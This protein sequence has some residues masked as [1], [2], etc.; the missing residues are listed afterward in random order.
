MP[1]GIWTDRFKEHLESITIDSKS[2]SN[3]QFIRSYS[4]NCT[5]TK[6]Y[7]EISCSN[8]TIHRMNSYD[9]KIHMTKLE[10]TFKLC[11]ILNISNMVLYNPNIKIK[12]YKNTNEIIKD[13]CDKRIVIYDERIKFII[14]GLEKELNILKYKVKFITEFIENTIKIIKTKK[15]VIIDQLKTKHYPEVNE[16]YDYLLKMPIYNLSQEKIDELNDAV[17]KKEQELEYIQGHTPK[18]LW[19]KEL[20][21]LLTLFTKDGFNKE[22]KISKVKKPKKLKLMDSN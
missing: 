21:E 12:K 17:K 20:K 16:N 6:I 22:L 8:E 9:E 5:D 2:K 10:K 13:Y 3:K 18:S 11:S 19:K 15:D 1:I 4:T 14:N 7:F